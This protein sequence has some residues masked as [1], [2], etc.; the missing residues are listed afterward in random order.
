M[1]TPTVTHRKTETTLCLANII[2]YFREREKGEKKG[3]AAE[4]LDPP[5]PPP[6]HQVQP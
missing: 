3:R 6:P 4:P 1:H 2:C 5:H